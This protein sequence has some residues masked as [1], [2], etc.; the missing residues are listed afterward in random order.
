MNI[1][2]CIF[3]GSFADELKMAAV[4]VV[5]GVMSAGDDRR[6][7]LKNVGMLTRTTVSH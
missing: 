7:Y 5:I 4:E 2:I 1:R 6:A 3:K